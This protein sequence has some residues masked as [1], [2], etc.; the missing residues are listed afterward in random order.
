MG[1]PYS[2]E[3]LQLAATYHWA[4]ST[5]ISVLVKSLDLLRGRPLIVVGSGGSL[6]ACAFAARLHEKHACLPARILTPLEFIRHPIP[7]TAGVLLL[8]AGGNNPDVLAAARHAIVSEYSP[9]VGLCS[10][11]DTRLKVL[12]APHRHAA[13][14]EF[15]GPSPRDGFL[16]TNSLLL[17]CTLLTRAYSQEPP[18]T[19]PA[20]EPTLEEQIAVD[21]GEMLSQPSVIALADG[22]AVV[23]AVDLESKWSESGF[24]AVVVTDARNFAHG[25]H[26]GLSRRLDDTLVLGLAVADDDYHGSLAAGATG[27]PA[28][29]D[30]LS[31]TLARLPQSTAVLALRSPL[32]AEAGALDLLVR[33]IRLAGEAGRRHGI[34]PG[35]PRVPAFGKTLYRAGIPLRLFRRSQ[36]EGARS[37]EDLWIR[38]K[39]TPAVWTDAT[40]EARESWRASC[41]AWV[42]KAESVRVGGVVLDYDGTL[43]E[44]DERFGVPAVEV[45]LALTRLLDAGMVVGIATGRGRSIVRALR[46]ITPE[47]VWPEI[48][49]GMYNGS[50]LFRLH[51]GEPEQ[52]GDT[53]PAKSIQRAYETLSGSPVLSHVAHFRKRPTQLTV[54]ALR[55]LPEGLL[56]RFILEALS[57]SSCF[58]V[59][60]L[61]SD[62]SVDIVALGDS[63]LY[64]VAEVER[65][66]AA[67]SGPG[68]TVMTIGDQGQEGGNDSLFLA[69]P[70]GLS[71]EHTSSVFDGCWNVAPAGERRTAALLGYLGGLRP[72]A[73]GSFR[74]SVAQA[75]R[76]ARSDAR[77]DEPKKAAVMEE[78]E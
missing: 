13:V 33:V 41:R 77:R 40:A 42:A 6:S 74:W 45:G 37:A 17:T 7:Q 12:L 53:S 19:L 46:D 18:A 69:R 66:L 9:I 2:D 10:R 14:F 23:A 20:L 15:V 49:V 60:V 70:L 24:G 36:G 16:A 72:R 29:H 73:D 78:A 61:A 31:T 35:R 56:R 75:S 67:A 3:L 52:P 57:A 71:V 76:S 21:L 50:V 63:K 30:I 44:E 48:L 1:R 43:C 65:V 22:W 8:S 28:G 58:G 51:E 47:R 32:S 55:P 34:D 38:R 11:A 68:L 64:V 5:D 54:H 62:H 25:R 59:D 27:W 26:Y 4:R 39:V